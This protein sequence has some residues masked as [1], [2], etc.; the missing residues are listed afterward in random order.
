L[1]AYQESKDNNSHSKVKPHRTLLA[2][3]FSGIVQLLLDGK[4]STVSAITAPALHPG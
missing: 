1:P 3:L 2:L 4:G